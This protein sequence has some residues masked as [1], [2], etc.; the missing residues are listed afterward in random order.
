[1]S[2]EIKVLDGNFEKNLRRQ[3][4]QIF[5]DNPTFTNSSVGRDSG[6]NYQII[7]RVRKEKNVTTDTLFKL[8]AWIK[9]KGL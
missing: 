5:K 1:M 3:I 8:D 4:K 9:N 6:I 7:G 2:K